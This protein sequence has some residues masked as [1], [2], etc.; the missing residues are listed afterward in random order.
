LCSSASGVLRLAGRAGL[1]TAS[2]KGTGTERFLE[3]VEEATNKWLAR[4]NKSR[5]RRKLQT[6]ETAARPIP[7]APPNLGRCPRPPLAVK[8]S[9]QQQRGCDE[10][11]TP[12]VV[13]ELRSACRTRVA[14]DPFE[15]VTDD[16]LTQGAA[17]R[18]SSETMR[19][20]GAVEIITHHT[21]T[22]LCFSAAVF[23]SRTIAASLGVW[24]EAL[25]GGLGH[26]NL[27]RPGVSGAPGRTRA[28]YGAQ[29][30]AVLTKGK[31]AA[32][33]GGHERLRQRE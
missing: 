25:A 30:F 15:L 24:G 22:S 1:E 20:L 29:D 4:S 6:S 23:A 33:V 8:P 16:G 26:P 14:L 18:F 10:F 32:S 17:P 12:S 28:K 5:T 31:A 27:D 2:E 11:G 7:L 21:T 13:R 3:R 9:G 19:A